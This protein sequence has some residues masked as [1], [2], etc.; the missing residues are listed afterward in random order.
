MVA[1]V[2]SRSS[3]SS[4]SGKSPDDKKTQAT[5]AASTTAYITAPA[6]YAVAS[7]S[8]SS[9]E[10]DSSGIAAR[11]G[12][13]ARVLYDKTDWYMGTVITVHLNGSEV[14]VRFDSGSEERVSLSPGDAEICADT[15]LAPRLADPPPPQATRSPGV[16]GKKYRLSKGRAGIRAVQAIG[17]GRQV[18]AEGEGV[19]LTEV[20]ARALLDTA[21]E[22]LVGLA[23]QEYHPGYGGGWE[24]VISEISSERVVRNLASCAG[25]NNCGDRN[26]SS[27][28]QVLWPES[29]VVV[30]S[31]R[32]VGRGEKE[33]GEK[34][35]RDRDY[36]YTR[37]M[38]G[39]L[40]RLKT[41]DKRREASSARGGGG[42]GEV[43]A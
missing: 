5:T 17:L 11:P 13:R 27:V 32:S 43:R 25:G 8:S 6:G 24:T 23:Y 22:K 15:E 29:V 7:E 12:D 34:E 16:S 28:N 4:D 35:E 42:V 30:Q 21:P 9:I 2:H 38:G 1:R 33:E 20:R 14:T 40:A 19:R 36:T 31:E 10:S 26:K 3:P 37:K 41:S 18:L 39:L